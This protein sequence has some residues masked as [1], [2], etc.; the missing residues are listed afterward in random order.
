MR[1]RR[2]NRAIGIALSAGVAVAT[3]A[4]TGVAMASGSGAPGDP[5]VVTSLPL[6]I[7]RDYTAASDSFS[8]SLNRCFSNATLFEATITV[9][10]P[11]V[12][13]VD[14]GGSDFD[15]VL[16]VTDLSSFQLQCSDDSALAGGEA[17]Q[18]VIT[19]QANKVYTVAVGGYSGAFGHLELHF[20]DRQ[21]VSATI[22]TTRTIQAN[23]TGTI[24]CIPGILLEPGGY[25]GTALVKGAPTAISLVGEICSSAG[26]RWFTDSTYP[27]RKTYR[28]TASFSVENRVFPA[29][30]AAASATVAARVR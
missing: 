22:D 9:P 7:E 15:T 11:T 20:S 8:E 27:L 23:L 28:V 18:V 10:E 14:T 16:A 4:A 12:L 17:S 21:A 3:L 6:T 26:T 24:R 19:L 5:F 29:D 30:R 2:T 13:T 1:N 25:S